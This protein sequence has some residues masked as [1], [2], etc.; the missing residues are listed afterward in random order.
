MVAPLPSL[1]R[2]SCGGTVVGQRTTIKDGRQ[3]LRF[4]YNQLRTVECPRCSRPMD[5]ETSPVRTER[6]KC[7]HCRFCGAWRKPQRHAFKA[8]SG[9]RLGPT[10][11]HH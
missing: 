10:E 11:L 3:F 2:R 8:T 1:T 9:A 5:L 7:H 6:Y 4:G